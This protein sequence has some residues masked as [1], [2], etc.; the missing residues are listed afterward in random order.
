MKYIIEHLEPRIYPWCLIEYEHISEIVGRENLIFTNANEKLSKLGK[1]YKESLK[2][3]LNTVFKGKKIC[4]LDASAKKM[5]TPE[6]DKEF[7]FLVFG[8]IL[9]DN[10]P[11]NRTMNEL[12][13]LNLPARNLGKEQMATDNAVYVSKKIISGVSFE[14]ILFKDG[15]EIEVGEGES[16]MLPF[17]YAIKEG[18][19]VISS[20]LVEYIKRK[21]GF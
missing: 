2:F 21:K 6:D 14:K 17:R 19:P 16:V 15:I 1:V 13:S 7:D 3:L 9:G 11:R 12:G 8:G 4:L 10:P 5:L 20:K 18:K